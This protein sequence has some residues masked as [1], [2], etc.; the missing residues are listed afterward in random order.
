MEG[1]PKKPRWLLW[2]AVALL[3]L[4]ALYALS[5]GPAL[6]LYG[7]ER[8]SF[9]TLRS[10]WPVHLRQTVAPDGSPLVKWYA[11]LWADR[12]LLQEVELFNR[13]FP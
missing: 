10:G 9:D 7:R 3:A 5:F 1:E 11:G 6:W 13:F 2:A 8:I 12:N 4:A